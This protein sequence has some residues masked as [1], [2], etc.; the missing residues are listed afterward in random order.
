VSWVDDLRDAMAAVDLMPA[1]PLV[2]D[3]RIHRFDVRGERHLSRSGWYVIHADGRPAAAFGS[4]RTGERHTWS[5]SEVPVTPVSRL[6]LRA[7]K[8]RRRSEQSAEHENAARR[9]ASIWERTS[10]PDPQHQYLQAK[11]VF[12]HG[13]RQHR[14]LLVV[15]LRDVDGRL[16]SLQFI[17]PTGEKRF[18]RGGRTR[19]LFFLIGK[20][21]SRTWLCEGYA[22]GASLHERFCEQVVCAMT[23]GNLLSV[24]EAIASAWGH[25]SLAIMGDDDW[26]TPGNPGATKARAAADALGCDWFLPEF[27]VERPTWATDF[28]D[29]AR[30]SRQLACRREETA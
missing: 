8:E 23:A 15:P 14:D 28:N 19:G 9:A 1:T 26:R 3:G 20:P 11:H 2:I 17:S 29:A 12:A 7:E 30:L 5:A 16:W 13:L 25:D 22:T 18:L 10:D 21:S 24:G 27:P 6:A 4:W